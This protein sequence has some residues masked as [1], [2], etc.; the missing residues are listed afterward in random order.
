MNDS[1][2][3]LVDEA[4]KLSHFDLKNLGQILVPPEIQFFLG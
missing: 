3:L 2:F 1:F 4:K